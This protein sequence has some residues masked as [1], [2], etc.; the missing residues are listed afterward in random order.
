MLSEQGHARKKLLKLLSTDDLNRLLPDEVLVYARR[1][2][3][4]NYL[5]TEGWTEEVAR[6][7]GNRIDYLIKK[8]IHCV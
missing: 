5:S 2:D 1:S 3:V 8:G 6:T 4:A 7:V